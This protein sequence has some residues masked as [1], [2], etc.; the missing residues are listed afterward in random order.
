MCWMWGPKS[1]PLHNC[2]FTVARCRRVTNT[3]ISGVT[4]CLYSVRLCS[5]SHQISNKSNVFT[6]QSVPLDE[7]SIIIDTKNVLALT[8][9]PWTSSSYLLMVGHG[10]IVDSPVGVW[11]LL[12]S[13]S[14]A[15]PCPSRRQKLSCERCGSSGI[16]SFSDTDWT[17]NNKT[18]ANH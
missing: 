3:F 13:L 16:K 5:L 4:P 11:K 12:K 18:I 1:L 17:V 6:A 7:F 10:V 2:I 9:S 8:E 15:S 14:P